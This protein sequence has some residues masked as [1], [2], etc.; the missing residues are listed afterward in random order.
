MRYSERALYSP[1]DEMLEITRA[2]GRNS[3][4]GNTPTLHPQLVAVPFLLNFRKNQGP[5]IKFGANARDKFYSGRQ[6]D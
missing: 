4:S 2:S 1:N 6:R 5:K 3:V